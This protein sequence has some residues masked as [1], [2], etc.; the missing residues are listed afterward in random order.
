MEKW[1]LFIPV[2]GLGPEGAPGLGRGGGRAHR[3]RFSLKSRVFSLK[4]AAVCLARVP[5][6]WLQLIPVT[7]SQRSCWAVKSLP[8]EHPGHADPR[9]LH[10]REPISANVA[11]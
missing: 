11:R 8:A 5:G 1:H 10:S 6:W 7:S 3:H 4:L 2:E 9:E